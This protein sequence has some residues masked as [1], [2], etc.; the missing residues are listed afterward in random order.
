MVYCEV[1]TFECR[2]GG[3]YDLDD[4]CDTHDTLAV[5]VS[6]QLHDGWVYS[7]P[8]GDCHC[9]GAGQDHSGPAHSVSK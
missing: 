8:V 1:G 3:C 5:R 7:H 6:E 2:K 4:L 9:R